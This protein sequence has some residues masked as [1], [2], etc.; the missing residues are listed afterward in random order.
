M[1]IQNPFSAVSPTGL[2]SQ[3]HTVLARTDQYLALHQIHQLLMT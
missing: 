3:V 2:D 1:R